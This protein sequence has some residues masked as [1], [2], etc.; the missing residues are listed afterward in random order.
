MLR[1]R[2]CSYTVF[3]ISG[4]AAGFFMLERSRFIS[5]AAFTAAMLTAALSVE[6]YDKTV[7]GKSGRVIRFRQMLV[8]MLLSGLVIFSINYIG[9]RYAERYVTGSTRVM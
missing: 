6:P 2:L 3:F 4:I 7:P 5:A 8:I 1:R 9:F